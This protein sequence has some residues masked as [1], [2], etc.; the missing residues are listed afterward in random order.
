[1]TGFPPKVRAVIVARSQGRCEA[2]TTRCQGVA[3]QIHHRC[4]RRLGG[5]SVGWVNKPSN[6]LHVCFGCH[7][8][9]ESH[10]AA[11][12]VHGWL[13]SQYTSGTAAD[14]P[15]LYRFRS[16]FLDDAGGV[17]YQLQEAS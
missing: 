10:R 5:S 1:M 2:N 13:V 7:A 4:P 11:A 16:A 6:G 12:V 15:V 8:F 14:V 3:T 9:I 17:T